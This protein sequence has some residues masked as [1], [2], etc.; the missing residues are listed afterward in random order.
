MELST[1]QRPPPSS[2]VCTWVCASRRVIS[3]SVRWPSAWTTSST[4]LDSA[5]ESL[6]TQV[7]TVMAA[8]ASL[9]GKYW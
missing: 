4:A 8:T 5:V 7:R 9:P 1:R 2:I 6:R 3:L